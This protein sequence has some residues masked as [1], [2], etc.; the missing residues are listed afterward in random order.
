MYAD[1]EYIPVIGRVCMDMTMVDVSCF[2]ESAVGRPVEILGA[3]IPAGE[4]AELANTIEYE[5]LCGISD[6]VPRVYEVT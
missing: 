4:L 5:I 6:R 3:H 2:G 1:G